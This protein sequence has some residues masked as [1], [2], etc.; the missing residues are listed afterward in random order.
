M[1]MFRGEDKDAVRINVRDIA[2]GSDD[3]EDEFGKERSN[4]SNK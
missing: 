4:K 2:P 3:S 1:S